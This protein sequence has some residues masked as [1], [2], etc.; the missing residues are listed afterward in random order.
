MQVSIISLGVFNHTGGPT[1]TIRDFKRALNAEVY[2]FCEQSALEKHKLAIAGARPVVSSSLPVLSQFCYAGKGTKEAEAAVRASDIVSCHSFYRYHALWTHKI[3]DACR[4][5]YSFVPHGILDPWVMRKNRWVKQLYLNFGGQRFIEDSSVVIFSTQTERDKAGTQFVLPQSAV[6]PWPVELVDRTDREPIRDRIRRL[7]GIPEEAHVLLFFGRLHPIKRPLETIEAVAKA[8][9]GE[10]HLV[11]VG[12]EDGVTKADCMQS[13]RKYGVEKRIHFVGAVYGEN[14]YHYMHAA[15]AYISLSFKE[16]FNYTAAE[17]LAA[18]LPVILSP[19]NDL[20]SELS[21][22]GCCLEIEDESL[23]SA[24]NAIK[25]FTDLSLPKLREMGLLGRKWVEANL[26]FD[27]FKTRLLDL[28]MKYA[29]S[30][31]K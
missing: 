29:K 10:L 7:L 28:H 26:S 16:N 4:V 18:G 11:I 3:C 5:P 27:L 17:S 12:N 23:Q 20:R 13:A 8:T 30:A 24:V 15:D 9:T 22:V 31:A 1:K 14:K 19:G 2:S 25:E 21:G 6:I